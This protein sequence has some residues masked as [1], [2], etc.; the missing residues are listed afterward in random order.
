MNSTHQAASQVQ[1]A[2][3]K[4]VGFLLGKTSSCMLKVVGGLPVAEVMERY[5]DSLD[6]ICALIK[7]IARDRDHEM[8]EAEA[9]AIALI[10]EVVSAMHSACVRGMTAAGGEA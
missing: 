6:G 4:E 10:T 5:E 8:D 1:Q 9:A 7:R 3:T 2:T